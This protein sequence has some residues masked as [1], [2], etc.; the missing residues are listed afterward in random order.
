MFGG[1]LLTDHD[2]WHRVIDNMGTILSIGGGD[3]QDARNAGL[4]CSGWPRTTDGQSVE[5]HW[6]CIHAVGV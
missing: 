1:I 6:V 4:Y 3:I 2:R 5:H